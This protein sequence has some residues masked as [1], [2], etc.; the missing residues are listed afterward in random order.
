MSSK[1]T[2][3]CALEC[4]ECEAYKAT[5]GNDKNALKRIAAEWSTETLWFTAKDVRCGGCTAPT[6]A[7]FAWA[8][9]CPL[10]SCCVSK[11]IPD[12]THCSDFPCK[13]VEQSPGGTKERLNA[14]KKRR[15]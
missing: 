1:V 6:K 12:C 9:E 3:Y 8:R 2:A 7:V 5:K 10:R 4:H 15:P 11:H 14:L 13:I